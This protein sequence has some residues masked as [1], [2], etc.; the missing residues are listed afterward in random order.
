MLFG[1]I[2]AEALVFG[3]ANG[4]ESDENMFKALVG[5]LR[6]MWPQSKVGV[7]EGTSLNPG[8]LARLSLYMSR[9][10]PQSLS[11]YQFPP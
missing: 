10:L 9:P 4:G 5:Q 1:G 2:A 3:E 8:R 11:A 7:L 6:P